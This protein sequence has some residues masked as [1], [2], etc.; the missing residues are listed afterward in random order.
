M[1]EI[2]YSNDAIKTLGKMPRAVAESIRAALIAIAKAPRARRGD[3][4]KLQGSELHRLRV[5][6]WRV[7]CKLDAGALL[8][9]VIKIGPRGDVYK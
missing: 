1:Y 8:I 4:K 2:R 6:G 9:L 7:I 3:F 5:G